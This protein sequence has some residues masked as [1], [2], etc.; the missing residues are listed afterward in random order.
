MGV[1]AGDQQGDALRQRTMV[2]DVGGKVSAEMIDGVERHTPGRGVGLGGRHPHHQGPGQTGTDGGGDDIGTG[3][4][5]GGQRPSHGGSERLEVRT[6]G[7]LRHHTAVAG[8]LVDAGG[9]LVGQ[10]C[11]G[12]VGVETGDTDSRFVTGTFDSQNGAR[13]H[14]GSRRMVK[15]SAPL[16]W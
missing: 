2:V 11:D 6:R 4:S 5:C 8:V 12:P 3:D 15:A 14:C 16:L 13:A 7:D 10:Q 1:P 9:H